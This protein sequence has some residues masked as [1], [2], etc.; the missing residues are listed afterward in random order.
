MTL[1][2][3]VRDTHGQSALSDRAGEPPPLSAVNER[4]YAAAWRLCPFCRRSALLAPA[5]SGIGKK[6]R[7][8]FAAL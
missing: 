8:D 2:G 1:S 6:C 5:L 7:T 3:F 4:S